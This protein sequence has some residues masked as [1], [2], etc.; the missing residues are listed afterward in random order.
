MA[1][2]KWSM[3]WSLALAHMLDARRCWHLLHSHT[4]SILRD[5]NVSCT[6]TWSLRLCDVNI[7]KIGT[8]GRCCAMAASLALWHMVAAMLASLAL[9]HMVDSARCWRLLYLHT[10]SMLRDGNVSCSCTHVRCCGMLTSLAFA[11]TFDAT[12]CWHLL[13]LHTWSMLRNCNGSCTCTHGRCD[14]KTSLNLAHM[15]DAARCW[16][17]PKTKNLMFFLTPSW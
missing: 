2:E 8:H 4:W 10:R 13:H 5:C 6:Y 3:L 17:I 12:R 11:R 14:V 1:N 16:R 15:V 9:A 7:P